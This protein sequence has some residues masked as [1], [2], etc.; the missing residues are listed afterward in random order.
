MVGFLIS[1]VVQLI[2]NHDLA[3]SFGKGWAYAI[4]LTVP[5]INFAVWPM[6]AFGD[7][8]YKGPAAKAA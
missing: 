8:T 3:R 4:G 1:L 6:L 7:A 5:V 2:V